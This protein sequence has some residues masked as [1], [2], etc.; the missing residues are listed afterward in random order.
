M[1]LIIDKYD[2]DILD[3]KEI[4]GKHSIFSNIETFN[5]IQCKIEKNIDNYKFFDNL[6]DMFSVK[7]ID[8][9]CK[10]NIFIN[11]YIKSI[12]YSDF[13]IVNIHFGFLMHEEDKM[14]VR[15]YKLRN[16]VK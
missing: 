8:D 11:C 13:I 1:V 7:I 3:Y 15:K 14:L 12:D 9:D 6:N 2:F 4:E 10:I 16:I 5:E